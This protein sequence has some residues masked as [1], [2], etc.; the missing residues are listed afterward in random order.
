MRIL[1]WIDSF[2]PLQGGAEILCSQL[3]RGLQARG[4]ESV[5]VSSL[6]DRVTPD[7]IDYQGIRVYRLPLM[8]ALVRRDLKQMGVL[9][10]RIAEIKQDFQPDLIHLNYT[11]AVT[12]YHLLFD[13]PDRSRSLATMHFLLPGTWG[14][15]SMRGE[16]LRAVGWVAAVSEAILDQARQLV[17]E[18]TPRSSVIYNGLQPPSLA[19][20]PLEF[21]SPNLLCLGRLVEDKG[22]DVAI[23]AFAA[24]AERHPRAR[25]VIS[26]DGTAKN[27]LEQQAADRGLGDRIS[28]T[29]WVDAEK[30]PE[31]INSATVVVMPSRWNEPFGLVALQA[32]QMA[33][34][35]VATR[36]GG[37]PEV[38]LHERTGLL[39]DNENS[40]AM[41]NAI[42]YL[43]D[44]P[45]VATNMG[46]AARERALK[47]FAYDRFVDEYESLYEK[48]VQSAAKA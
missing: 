32:A 38:V 16:M 12:F 8:R 9:K 31:A 40:A 28:F 37:L 41:A 45:D 33:R 24:V 43:L 26:G 2:W 3:L 7:E 39:V 27:A 47:K 17:P 30:V 5:V 48:L 10:R 44:H 22:F 18:I 4:H 21:D 36:V 42:D 13:K 20:A 34:P 6:Q 35:I 29:G 46:Q 19:P 14:E 25:L 1:H 23:S 15:N 11:G